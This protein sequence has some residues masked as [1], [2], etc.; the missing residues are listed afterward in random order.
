MNPALHE[1]EILAETRRICQTVFNDPALVITRESNAG[2]I[3]KWDSMSNLILIDELE[4][5]FGMKFSLDEI[6]EAQNVG[7][8]CDIIKKKT[9]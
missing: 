9:S 2:A 7:D 4:K 3:D 8:L 6:L 5:R 1:A